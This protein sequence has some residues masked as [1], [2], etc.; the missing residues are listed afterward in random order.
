MLTIR[1]SAA[2]CRFCPRQWWTIDDG[3]FDDV[4]KVPKLPQTLRYAHEIN[5]HQE[6]FING[7]S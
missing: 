3:S 5:V 4:L 2:K 1:F 7:R 6:E